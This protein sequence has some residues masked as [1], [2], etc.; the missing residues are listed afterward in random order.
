MRTAIVKSASASRGMRSCRAAPPSRNTSSGWTCPLEPRRS[1]SV[2]TATRGSAAV[3]A[4]AVILRYRPAVVPD[5]INPSSVRRVLVTKLRHHGDVL[6]ASPVLQ[7]LAN[8]MPHA[9]IDALVYS[10]TRGMLEGHPALS[11][12]H[13]VDRAWKR[14]GLAA[15]SRH[16][17]KLLGALQE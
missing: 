1:I 6:L 15:Q 17:G 3:W 5:A 10:D 9:E 11:R 7:V 14:A 2:R 8:R 13:L 4:M 16:E 12:L